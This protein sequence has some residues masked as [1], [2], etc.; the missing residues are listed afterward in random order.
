[1]CKAMYDSDWYGVTSD[2]MNSYAWD[3]AILFIQKYSGDM[4]YAKQNSLNITLT[5]TGVN[6]DERCH[7]HDMASNCIEWT[8]ETF[9]DASMPSVNRG[10]YYTN[11]NASTNYRSSGGS[12]TIANNRIAFRPILYL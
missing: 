10:G 9:K 11:S 2:L 8:T 3:T 1:M 12:I 7:I 4:D 5:N 6:G